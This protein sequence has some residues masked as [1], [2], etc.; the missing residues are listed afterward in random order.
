MRNN[1][2]SQYHHLYQIGMI[3]DFVRLRNFTQRDPNSL[4]YQPASITCY[5]NG[6]ILVPLG[7]GRED[8]RPSGIIEKTRH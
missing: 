2:N 4:M 5:H 7:Y 1:E 3:E 6:G 8:Q